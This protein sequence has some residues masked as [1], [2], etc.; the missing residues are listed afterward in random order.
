MR[1][2]K[3]SVLLPGGGFARDSLATAPA[4]CVFPSFAE[5]QSGMR[6]PNIGAALI[7]NCGALVLEGSSASHRTKPKPIPDEAFRATRIGT[8]VTYTQ[9]RSGNGSPWERQNQS[10]LGFS[11]FPAASAN[12]FAEY[13]HVDG[14]VPLNFLSGGNF[15]DGST[16]SEQGVDTD[17][18][19]V[20]AQVAF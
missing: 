9:R 15:P 6:P 8:K 18:L 16:W 3:T 10:V 4:A 12:L 19:L 11:W 2:A 17:V 1:C 20:G 13:I 7:A 14:F 5:W